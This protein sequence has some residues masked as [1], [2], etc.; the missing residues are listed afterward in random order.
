M[1]NVLLKIS[2][3]SLAGGMATRSLAPVGKCLGFM[4]LI[5]LLLCDDALHK[6]EVAMRAESFI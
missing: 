4:F 2:Y 5:R 1:I 6:I 3:S